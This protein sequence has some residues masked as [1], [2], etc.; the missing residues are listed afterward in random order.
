VQLTTCRLRTHS[1]IIGRAS[2]PFHNLD[3]PDDASPIVPRPL[4]K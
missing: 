2:N 1:S 4:G 3:A